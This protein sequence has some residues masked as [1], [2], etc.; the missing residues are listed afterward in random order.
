MQDERGSVVGVD[1]AK[2]HLDVALSTGAATPPASA[3]RYPGG[4]TEREVEIMALIAEGR[5]NPDIADALA[6]SVR[7]VSTHVTNILAKI[8]AANRTEAA[9]YANKHG[10]V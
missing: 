6:V 7:T 9:T 4:L 5:A 8:G 3:P 1:I 10:P 2:P